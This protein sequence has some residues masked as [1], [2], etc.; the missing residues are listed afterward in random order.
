[1]KVLLLDSSAPVMV[2]TYAIILNFKGYDARAVHNSA[3]A[4]RL[5]SEF[6]PDW[7]FMILNN[8]HDAEP[9]DVVL[10]ILR[11]HPSCKFFLTA[12][13]AMPE[14]EEKLWASGYGLQDVLPLPLYPSDLLHMLTSNNSMIVRAVEGQAPK[15]IMFRE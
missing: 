14:F 13:R 9:H 1:M 15:F 3:E 12:G 8:I 5:A 10:D 7:F 2:D 6:R 11:I 4:V